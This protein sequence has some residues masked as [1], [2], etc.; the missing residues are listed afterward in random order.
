MPMALS[1]VGEEGASRAGDDMTGSREVRA[2]A[3][4]RVERLPQLSSV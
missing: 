1:Q 2:G 4:T 3:T